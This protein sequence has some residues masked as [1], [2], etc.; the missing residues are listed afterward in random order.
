MERVYK[1]AS[2]WAGADLQKSRCSGI[3]A[4]YTSTAAPR[5]CARSQDFMNSRNEERIARRDY[6]GG[7]IQMRHATCWLLAAQL[8]LFPLTASSADADK[9]AA[10]AVATADPL[11]QT[12]QAE[13]N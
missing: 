3:L 9:P 12:M 10:A 8:A 13:L 5:S 11:L 4:H 2:D 6:L 1:R 7:C